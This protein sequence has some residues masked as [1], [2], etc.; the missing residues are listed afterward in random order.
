M[1]PCI[2]CFLRKKRRSFPP[3]ERKVAVLL[4]FPGRGDKPSFSVY[5]RRTRGGPVWAGACR[6]RPGFM[7]K[8]VCRFGQN[9]RVRQSRRLPMTPL[10]ASCSWTCIGHMA[11]AGTGQHQSRVAIRACNAEETL[12]ERCPVGVP[13]ARALRRRP[14]AVQRFGKTAIHR[15]SPGGFKALKQRHC[16]CPI[17]RPSPYSAM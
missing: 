13:D 17:P 8:L 15:E 3:S 7:R 11:Q 10:N 5:N 2:K 6:V 16:F 9:V 14:A 12:I 4:Y 1:K